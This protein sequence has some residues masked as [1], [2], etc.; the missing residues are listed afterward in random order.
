MT[1]D[2]FLSLGTFLAS[3]LM[4]EGI[5]D[6][7]F[8]MESAYTGYFSW[9]SYAIHKAISLVFTV[10]TCGVGA[11]LSRGAQ[12]SKFGYK[13]GG[14]YLKHMAGKALIKE[15]GGKVILKQAAFQLGKKVIK[16]VALSAGNF[17]IK[18][19]TETLQKH[20]IDRICEG[21]IT[22]LDFS[23]SKK[24]V[25]AL[26]E[27]VGSVKAEEI[28]QKVTE[29]IFGPGSELQQ[30]LSTLY[31]YM[32]RAKNSFMEALGNTASKTNSGE[33]GLA[34]QVTNYITKSVTVTT[35]IVDAT[36]CVKNMD[37]K[38]KSEIVQACQNA[39]SVT[40]KQNKTDL[41]ND[42][43]A[44][45]LIAQWRG[46]IKREVSDKVTNT[47]VE[48]I[49]NYVGHELANHAAKHVKKAFTSYRQT[50][51][52]NQFNEI[53]KERDT[54]LAEENVNADEI[55][56][57]YDEQMTKLLT[58][59]KNPKLYA[60]LVREG[61][62][63]GVLGLKAIS[64]ATGRPIQV[65]DKDGNPSP[66][67]PQ[68]PN[69]PKGKPIVLVF[70]PGQ[71]GP[72]GHAGHFVSNGQTG[73]GRNDC[74]FEAVKDQGVN[75]SRDQVA[76]T[77]EKDTHIQEHIRLGIDKHFIGRK[78]AV[79]GLKRTDEL[80]KW[81]DEQLREG[82]FDGQIIREMA[83]KGDQW[84]GTGNNELVPCKNIR[85][86]FK[87]NEEY[88]SKSEA[89]GDIDNNNYD[90]IDA[91]NCVKV[92]TG[93]TVF[94][95]VEDDGTTT[96]SGHQ[97][98]IFGKGKTRSGNPIGIAKGSKEYHAALNEAV[99][100]SSTPSELTR[101]VI[102][103]HMENIATKESLQNMDLSERFN[104][105][106]KHM[107][108]DDGGKNGFITRIERN[109]YVM[110]QVLLAH[111]G[112]VDEKFRPQISP[113]DGYCKKFDEYFKSVKSNPYSKASIR[114]IEKVMM[115]V[116]PAEKVDDYSFENTT[117]RMARKK[118]SGRSIGGRG[119]NYRRRQTG[120]AKKSKYSRP[121]TRK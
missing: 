45:Q 117:G 64:V 29:K 8:A 73:E 47:I 109:R 90:F 17:A 69:A 20:L 32:N 49:L 116:P 88:K 57:K 16:S 111:G 9:K 108:T 1:Y 35:T 75:I 80:S 93:L 14:D 115:D 107:K 30:Q 23:D 3:G 6:I 60:E 118:T 58:K 68:D 85:Q 46:Q 43:L 94:E 110:Y 18:K 4:S 48:P 41:T 100:N 106:D 27:N 120:F 42:E 97:G 11:F 19:V 51:E 99:K 82:N 65:V 56:K 22:D 119:Q 67:F 55:N 103:A 31:Q 89:S 61:V 63:M 114:K 66:H 70:E 33:L 83:E 72:E 104:A 62:P 44:I 54:K 102:K 74:L 86:L 13:I 2:L 112:D 26:C 38:L 121:T 15:V 78:G 21:A 39:Q 87:I 96:L 53:K 92:D 36:T 59:T 113:N 7:M 28:L 40:K 52:W 25:L 34:L 50:Q 24:E 101:N 81:K 37:E 10:I 79:G 95:I 84:K 105:Y 76:N 77:I 5:S 12:F 91:F 71:T 98:A